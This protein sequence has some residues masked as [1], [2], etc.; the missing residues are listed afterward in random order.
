MSADIH[1]DEGDAGLPENSFPRGEKMHGSTG[2]AVPPL[3]D[4]PILRLDDA[5]FKGTCE[6]AEDI[7]SPHVY[8]HGGG[9]ARIGTAHDVR[10]NDTLTEDGRTIG[11]DGARRSPTQSHLIPVTS[12]W[13][14]RELSGLATIEKVMA[15]GKVK[16][17]SC[18]P[19]LAKNILH[20]GSPRFRELAGISTAPFLRADGSICDE[21][22]Y[23]ERSR[24]LYA[25]NADFPPIPD[26]VSKDEAADALGALVDVVSEFPFASESALS[27][28]IAQIL[29]EPARAALDRVPIF[30][31]TSQY[32]GSGKSL[33]NEVVSLIGHGVEPALRD[34]PTNDEEMAKSLLAS[35][36]GGDRNISFDNLPRGYKV[37]S[38]SLAKFA[39]QLYATGRK[40]GES[41]NISA[42][43]LA[44]VSITGNNITPAGDIA[45]RSVVIRLDGDVPASELAKRVFKIKNLRQYVRAHRAELLT[46]ALTVL[47][48]HR[49]SGHKSEF[50]PLPSFENWSSTVRDALLWLGMADPLE[51]QAAEGDD[52]TSHHEEAFKLLVQVF[53]GREFMAAD[54]A[55]YVNGMLGADGALSGAL[56]KAGCAEPHNSLKVGYWLR[57][58]RDMFGAGHK[59]V[60]SNDGHKGNGSKW[61]LKP[62]ASS[63]GANLDLVG[64]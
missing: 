57:D 56:I 27:A 8:S 18:S 23:D 17:V 58:K 41:R 31:D 20:H 53:A 62:R 64:G 34:W 25:P 33:F 36:V 21:P 24:V 38:G 54:I 30:L 7:L 45:R 51:T 52:E 63:F 13:I 2:D 35:V 19:R 55:A 47:R 60:R 43:N 48:G 12:E 32:A 46:A 49:Q 37:R 9:L 39:T 5:D 40:L 29:T 22:G 15:D 26:T 10:E 44:T 50:P 6:R 14:E 61:Q 16:R 11:R 1:V 42:T 3:P 4:K 59:L 28:A